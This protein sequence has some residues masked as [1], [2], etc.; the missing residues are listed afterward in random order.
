MRQIEADNRG[1]VLEILEM[2]AKHDP[3]VQEKMKGK[4]NAKYTSRGKKK[5]KKNPRMLGKYGP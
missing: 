1:N 5:T 4:Q 2:I 3:V